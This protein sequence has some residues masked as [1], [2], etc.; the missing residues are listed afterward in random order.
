MKELK[1]FSF[2]LFLIFE[3]CHSFDTQKVTDRSQLFYNWFL[4][5]GGLESDIPPKVLWSYKKCNDL[6]ILTQIPD[7]NA[8]MN[9]VYMKYKLGG[10]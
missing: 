10:C 3:G 2:V 4:T 7:S 1:Y 5:E 6:I 8:I 9:L